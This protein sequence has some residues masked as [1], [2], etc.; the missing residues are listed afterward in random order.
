VGVIVG[1]LAA[2]RR[3]PFVLVVILAAGTTGLLRLAG[4]P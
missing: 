4:L 1:A 3:V 2:W